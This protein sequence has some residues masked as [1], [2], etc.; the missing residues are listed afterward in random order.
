MG[1][2]TWWAGYLQHIRCLKYFRNVS[3][4]CATRCCKKKIP[5]AIQLHNHI[6]VFHDTSLLGKT[7]YS[8]LHKATQRLACGSA[9]VCLAKEM[10]STPRKKYR[11]KTI[12]AAKTS[13]HPILTRYLPQ[14]AGDSNEMIKSYGL[15]S[16]SEII[17]SFVLH[18]VNIQVTFV[19]HHN[20][21]LRHLTLTK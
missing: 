8:Y 11:M 6:S 20:Y 5:S 16:F 21:I 10:Y 19:P 15:L 1:G 12:R 7:G 3:K 2:S 4:V 14:A 18:Q 17:L 13:I 9:I